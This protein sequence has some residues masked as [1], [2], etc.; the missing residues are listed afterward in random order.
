MR[1]IKQRQ[2]GAITADSFTYK[3]LTSLLDALIG[4]IEQGVKFD[5][6]QVFR[7]V[8]ENQCIECCNKASTNYIESM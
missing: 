3:E 6:E 5:L 4:G 2:I 7:L 8:L 1:T